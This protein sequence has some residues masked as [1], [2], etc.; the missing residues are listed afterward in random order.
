MIIILA[1][2]FVFITSVHSYA[3]V[4]VKTT[5]SPADGLWQ[6]EYAVS[7][8]APADKE[9]VSLAQF[10][11]GPTT[12]VEFPQWPKDTPRLSPPRYSIKFNLFVTD[13]ACNLSSSMPYFINLAYNLQKLDEAVTQ[14]NAGLKKS[15][16]QAKELILK[17]QTLKEPL[18]EKQKLL[19]EAT[20]ALQSA[21]NDDKINVFL[22][23]ISHSL[24]VSAVKDLER[25]IERIDGLTK[26]LSKDTAVVYYDFSSA[27]VIIID[28][29]ILQ[30]NHVITGSRTWLWDEIPPDEKVH[31]RRWVL[32]EANSGTRI[33]SSNPTSS[34]NA[35]LL[36]K[37]I[38]PRRYEN[39][40]ILN[41]CLSNVD[42]MTLNGIQK[43]SIASLLGAYKEHKDLR[44]SIEELQKQINQIK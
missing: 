43:K 30:T 41:D 4:E 12:I 2:I 1:I 28:P 36:S 16:Q 37:Y 18:S 11:P 39:K 27:P 42:L 35:T 5:G 20:T 34:A 38:K 26:M 7:I 17:A 13:W 24:S 23:F 10:P 33:I 31:S 25:Y 22:E 29:V 14:K 32:N 44:L 21:L 3:G 8:S 6:D 9:T 19:A 40:I 15:I